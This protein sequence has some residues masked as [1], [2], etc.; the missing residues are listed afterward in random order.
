[1][2]VCKLDSKL[3]KDLKNDS[4]KEISS[5]ASTLWQ[6][7][8]G[9]QFKQKFGDWESINQLAGEGAA[10]TSRFKGRVDENGEPTIEAF[11]ETL[12]Q[13]GIDPA[14]TRQSM[15]FIEHEEFTPKSVSKAVLDIETKVKLRI[16]RLKQVKM[17]RP[18][19]MGESMQFLMDQMSPEEE[20]QFR[21]E[22]SRRQYLDKLNELKASLE[23]DLE[24][25][26]I[27]NYLQ[28]VNELL[29]SGDNLFGVAG[30]TNLDNIYEYNSRLSFFSG[31]EDI[32]NIID[33]APALRNSVERSNIDYKGLAARKSKLE[34]QFEAAAI[35]A[36]AEKWGNIP[37]KAYATAIRDFGDSFTPF[38]EYKAVSK[39][40][41]N[42][43]RAQYKKDKA[44]HVDN[45]LKLN[46]K[47]ITQAEIDR[48][49]QLL[50]HDPQDLGRLSSVIMDARNMNNDLISI[51]VELLDVADY[52][53]MRDTVNMASDLHDLW[54]EFIKGRS[55]V[56]QRKLYG[57]MIAKDKN[58]K[59]TKYLVGKIRRSFWEKRSEMNKLLREAESEFG[60]DSAAYE[61]AQL[62]Y[63]TW[64]D[65]N[66]IEWDYSGAQV[67]TEEWVDPTYAY[68][69][70]TNNKEDIEYK[71]Y[72]QLRKMA[73]ARDE[74]YPALSGRG[75]GLKLPSIQKS[76]MET[77]FEGGL[78]SYVKR[79]FKD[80]FTITGDDID[81]HEED[82]SKENNDK[83][84]SIE[85]LLHTRLNEDQTQQQNIPIYYRKDDLVTVEEQS[86]DLA[87][88]MLMDYW[89]SVNFRE[90]SMIA[91]ELEVLKG[92]VGS[93]NRKASPSY[94]G[95]RKAE[96][97]NLGEGREVIVQEG[98]PGNTSN[99]YFA[100]ESLISQRLYGIKKLGSAQ[101]NKIAS[102][103][104]GWT[105]D[106]MLM[107]NWYSAVA[108]VNQAK[109][110]MFVESGA[111]VFYGVDFSARDVL[112]AEYKFQKEVVNGKILGDIGRIRPTALTNLLGERFQAMQD[113]SPSAKKFMAATK[114]SQLADKGALHGAH[115]MGEH[116]VQHLLM[117]SYMNAAKVRNS[118][119]E[120]INVSGKVVD[121][122]NKAMSM[123]EMYEV[124]DGRL[125]VRQ[126]LDIASVE[127]KTGRVLSDL[128]SEKGL[129]TAEFRM[130]DAMLELNYYMNGN[131]DSS[132]ASHFQRTIA[133]KA[134]MMLRKWMPPGYLKRFRGI[135]TAVPFIN[136][137][138]RENL[139]MEDLAY[140]RHSEDFSYGTYTETI[141]FVRDI[142]RKGEALSFAL[143]TQNVWHKLSDREKAAVHKTVLEFATT[144]TSYLVSSLAYGIAADEPDKIKK[145]AIMYVAFFARRMYSETA[146]YANPIETFM[147]LKNPAAS[148]S[149][150]EGALEAFGQLFGDVM[151]GELEIYKRGKRKGRTKLGKEVRDILPILKQFDRDVETSLKY[152]Q[153]GGGR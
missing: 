8:H 86:F 115:S 87:S 117:Y 127:L 68:F 99:T 17:A 55:T 147:I 63:N 74:N 40:K 137:V 67:V 66:T 101:A 83:W 28:V 124:V 153:M 93:P 125:V 49:K 116:Y 26:A 118:K 119:G 39:L 102:S 22:I 152:L 72:W 138:P 132:N 75:R 34:A 24:A 70:D 57:R 54:K 69:E 105:G 23:S 91:P 89:G 141:R 142:F 46:E 25:V 114:V 61:A 31:L 151:A 79:V 44:A 145:R 42:E 13:Q 113:W 15:L 106:V 148:V 92:A 112:T 98:I 56:D 32:I 129:K 131:Y 123:D 108:S 149:M 111:G 143:Q 6:M 100:L 80:T 140:S 122:R 95:K 146:F 133:G 77:V 136:L 41:G 64:M 134:T 96:R 107:L 1:M 97:V 29:T 139:T 82:N 12:K 90:K 20:K 30:A 103:V 135:S 128:N 33:A 50:S 18:E 53:V 10:H 126:G 81:L 110:L 4:D 47:E 62:E 37:G 51:A 9:P 65:L 7:I 45:L 27:I 120:Y 71:M 16:N 58:G 78:V 144:V 130:K 59:E 85:K 48:V 5:R 60:T 88:I 19:D 104:M 76:Q 36:I 35:D 3:Y 14:E 121:S 150:I 109:T 2:A 73:S 11:K 43:L 38:S 94:A 21:I 52:T 84:H